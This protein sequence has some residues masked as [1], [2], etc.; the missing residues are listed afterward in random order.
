MNND[1]VI[2]TLVDNNDG[3]FTYTSEDGTITIYDSK[4]TV[5]TSFEQNGDSIYYVDENLD[6]TFVTL[7]GDH[8]WYK[9]G[10]TNAPTDISDSIFT[11]GEIQLTNYPND[12]ADDTTAHLNV[13]YTDGSGNIKSAR[14][15]I[16]PPAVALNISTVSVSNLFNY[17]N[18][19]ATQLSNAGLTPIAL[20]NLDFYVLYYDTAIFDNVTISV[21]G[22]LQYDVIATSETHAVIDVRFYTK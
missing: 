12:R 5:L 13:L 6:T 18:H 16:V 7:S 14:R 22:E 11:G 17:Y 20:A 10:T 4:D 8:D 21:S 1:T 15:E 9:I 19:Y 2:T 3:T